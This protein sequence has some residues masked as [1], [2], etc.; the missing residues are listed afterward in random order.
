MRLQL[1]KETEPQYFLKTKSLDKPL[2][3][4]SQSLESRKRVITTNQL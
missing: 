4:E 3:H 2:T 1:R